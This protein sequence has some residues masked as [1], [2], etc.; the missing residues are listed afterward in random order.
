MKKS[1]IAAAVFIFGLTTPAPAADVPEYDTKKYCKELGDMAGGSSQLELACRNQE[2]QIKSRLTRIRA[3]ARSI[4]Y[5]KEMGDMAGGS[6]ALYEQC[7]QQEAESEKQL[8]N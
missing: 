1:I 3:S 6:Y 8:G 5:C 2:N 4:K 7:L